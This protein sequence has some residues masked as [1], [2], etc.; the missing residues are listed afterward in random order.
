MFK[1]I[2][3]LPDHV[4][5]IDVSGKVT[6]DD[7]RDQLNPLIEEKLRSHKRLDM[8]CRF[9]DDWQGVEPGAMWQDLRVGMGSIGHWGRVAMVTDSIWLKNSVNFFGF[10]WPGHLRHFSLD[11]YQQSHDW[12]C[13]R[14]R[15]TIR[16]DIS[17]QKG[18]VVLEPDEQ[19]SLSEDDFHHVTML[20]DAYLEDHE[21]INGILITSRRFPGWEGMGAMLSHL[22]F[23]SAHHRKIERVAIV[24]DSPLGKFADHAV[25]H[26]IKAEV[27]SFEYDRQLDALNWLQGASDEV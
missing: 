7:Y 14:D 2:P 9:D 17:E 21:K 1:L 19:H 15:A 11:E 26:F 3:D 27:R 18:I 12:V 22:K 6:A 25:D 5:G 8:L 16:C 4:I 20:V 13:E 23:V 10:L 24:T